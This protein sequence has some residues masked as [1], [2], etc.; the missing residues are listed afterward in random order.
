MRGSN[1]DNYPDRF[2]SKQSGYDAGE[3]QLGLRRT[4]LSH[5]F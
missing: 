1:F 3:R 2:A 4:T 5:G